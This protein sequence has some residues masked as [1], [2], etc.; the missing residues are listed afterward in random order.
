MLLVLDVAAVNITG[1]KLKKT[2]LNEPV[3]LL[4]SL[5]ILIK[6]CFCRWQCD[7]GLSNG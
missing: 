6:C 5:Y 1:E 2:M 7:E 4:T 3:T